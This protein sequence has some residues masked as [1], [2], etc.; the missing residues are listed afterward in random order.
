[1]R[2]IIYT[3]T[4]TKNQSTDSQ[5]VALKTMVDRSN[6]EL[7]DIIED[8][9]VSGGKTQHDRKGMKQL[10]LMVN[11]RQVDVVC[12][13]SVDRLGRKLTD[14]LEIAERMEEIGRCS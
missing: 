8:I 5:L 13:Y 1:M 7:V 2:A 11:Q 4:S 14:V 9:G 6:F 3:R 10:M 12:V